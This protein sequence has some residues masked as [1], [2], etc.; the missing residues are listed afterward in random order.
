M[1]TCTGCRETKP[2]DEFHN[3]KSK[4]DGKCFRCKACAIAKTRKW[5]SE[6]KDRH[7]AQGK[8]YY[9]A[10]REHEAARQADYYQANPHVHWEARYRRRAKKYGFEVVIESFTR[11]ELI[12]RWG[13]ACWHCGGLFEQLDHLTAVVHGGHHTIENCRP[14][15]AACNQRTWRESGA[16]SE[17]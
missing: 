12:A 1:K 8:A 9:Q 15:C 10:N 14:S 6:N 3:D 16:R 2:R 5:Y 13:D 11:D 17:Q 4:K 7:A